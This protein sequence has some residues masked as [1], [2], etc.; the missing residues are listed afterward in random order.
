[1]ILTALDDTYEFQ[2]IARHEV[3]ERRYAC[4]WDPS[5]RFFLI[6][7]RKTLPSDTVVPKSFH[8]YNILGEL[9]DKK[10]GQAGLDQVWFRPRADDILNAN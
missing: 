2:K 8:F 10:E 7:G 3:R 4:K 5:G 6:Q 1:M 9:I